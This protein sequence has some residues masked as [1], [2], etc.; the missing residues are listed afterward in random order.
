MRRTDD[1]P[2][3]GTRKLLVDAAIETLKQK[4]FGGASA[5]AI[6]EAAG[7]NQALI[8][9]H[10][11]SVTN[12]LLAALDAV[13][14]DRLS[15]YSEALE[16]VGSV[17]DL[18]DAATGIFESDLDAGYITVLAEM[19]AGASSSP[20]LGAEV[21]ARIG[22]WRSFAQDAIE[23]SL[24]GSFLSQAL[25]APDVAYAVV[26]LYL[27]LEMLSHLDGDRGPAIDLF[28]HAKHLAPLFDAMSGAP[29]REEGR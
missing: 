2:P 21:A 13:S 9:Y 7:S 27:G 12:L 24:G 3:S 23:R 17:G 18:V 16:S 14:A 26:A 4:G 29:S 10:F 1:V 25:P 5:R 8:F 15:Q 28:A 11:G 6:A 22:P 19:I 20:G